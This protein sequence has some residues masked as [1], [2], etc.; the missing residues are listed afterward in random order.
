MYLGL[1]S[2]RFF[3]LHLEAYPTGDGQESGAHQLSLAVYPAIYE[4]L[5]ILV[6]SR[7]SSNSGNPLTY[8]RDECSL[9]EDSPNSS[10]Q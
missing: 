2:W 7:I 4:V 8:E 1:F 9:Y 5:Y 6:V 3:N 10:L